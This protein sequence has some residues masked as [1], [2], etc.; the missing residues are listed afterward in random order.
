MHFLLAD[1]T[2]PIIALIGT[3]VWSL[4]TSPFCRSSSLTTYWA[5][6]LVSSPL[7]LVELN[8]TILTKCMRARQEF[9]FFHQIKTQRALQPLSNDCVFTRHGTVKWEI[10]TYYFEQRQQQ[11]KPRETF[12]FNVY[13]CIVK[14][15]IAIR[16]ILN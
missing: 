14:I 8:Q 12:F 5:G 15:C 7:A 16:Q 13:I 11:Q 4:E 6:N 3:F 1:L 9:R 2:S 10:N